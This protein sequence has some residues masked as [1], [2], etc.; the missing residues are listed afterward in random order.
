M[1]ELARD[2]LLDL[3]SLSFRAERSWSRAPLPCHSERSEES[4]IFLDAE[5]DLDF[6]SRLEQL[7]CSAPTFPR[8]E[9]KMLARPIKMVRAKCRASEEDPGF[10]A[11]LRMTRERSARLREPQAESKCRASEKDP[12]FFAAL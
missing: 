8:R 10:F 3:G 11:A 4:R 7:R 2:R 12:G 5:E 6:A 9:T 1:D